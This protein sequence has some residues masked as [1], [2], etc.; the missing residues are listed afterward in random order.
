MGKFGTL[1]AMLRGNS[2]DKLTGVGG[3]VRR[4]LGGGERMQLSSSYDLMAKCFKASSRLDVGDTS[5]GVK[6]DSKTKNTILTGTQRLSPVES[7]SPSI[8]LNT[9]KLSYRWKK[10]LIGGFFVGTFRPGESVGLQWS[11]RSAA[12]SG[13]WTTSAMIP[14]TG[15]PNKQP[16]VSIGRSWSF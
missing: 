12:G 5:V 1:A 4:V 9:G 8:D 13:S 14:L 11:D 16:E 3:S 15:A 7:L 10:T 2:D 6:Y